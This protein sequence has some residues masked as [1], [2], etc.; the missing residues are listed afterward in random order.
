MRWRESS[1]AMISIVQF[2]KGDKGD[3]GDT[4]IRVS[5]D[6]GIG[7]KKWRAVTGYRFTKSWSRGRL[8]GQPPPPAPPD[9]AGGLMISFRMHA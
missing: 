7:E 5:A 4:Y 3:K 1:I 2:A 8:H 6:I 9:F